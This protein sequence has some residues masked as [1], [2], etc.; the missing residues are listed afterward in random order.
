MFRFI[1]IIETRIIPN[2]VLETDT[3]RCKKSKVVKRTRHSLF[4]YTQ[5][6]F[7]FTLSYSLKISRNHSI[8]Y[9]KLDGAFL[10]HFIWV[11][12]NKLYILVWMLLQ[13]KLYH[14]VTI[15]DTMQITISFSLGH[16]NPNI[17][18]FLLK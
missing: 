10:Q 16:L 3:Y 1:V 9:N 14:S 7:T 8:Q 17:Y 18:F 6:S 4:N 11:G 2:N 13:T 5:C 12:I 15:V